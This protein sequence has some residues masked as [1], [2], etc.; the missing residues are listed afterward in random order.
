[1]CVTHTVRYLGCPHIHS[2]ATVIHEDAAYCGN[3]QV[4]HDG[5]SR[6]NEKCPVCVSG[7]GD[8]ISRLNDVKASGLSPPDVDD[9]LGKSRARST[10]EFEILPEHSAAHTGSGC[11]GKSVCSSASFDGGEWIVLRDGDLPGHNI[12]EMDV[13]TSPTRLAK[14]VAERQRTGQSDQQRDGKAKKGARREEGKKTWDIT[15]VGKWISI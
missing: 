1:M 2:Y 10:K 13:Q 14:L 12:A 4:I 9:G 7:E 11:P 3:Q 6:W 8:D 15:R 5:F